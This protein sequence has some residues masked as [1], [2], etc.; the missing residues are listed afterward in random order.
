MGTWDATPFGNDDANDW[1][2]GLDDVDDLSLIEAAFDAVSEGYIESFE[3][4][5]AIAAAEVLA[6]LVGRPGGRNAYTDKVAIWCE[7]HPIEVPN[8]LIER[9]VRSLQRVL[10]PDSELAELWDGQAEWLGEVEGV[11]G[12]LNSGLL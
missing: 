11:M 8:A 6:W 5:C 12:R 10:S 3:G 1:A 4:A 9:A 2:Y 7:A